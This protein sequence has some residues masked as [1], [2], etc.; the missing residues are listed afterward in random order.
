MLNEVGC[1]LSCH[2]SVASGKFAPRIN[3]QLVNWFSSNGE[4]DSLVLDMSSNSTYLRFVC[5][6]AANQFAFGKLNFASRAR[7][8]IQLVSQLKCENDSLCQL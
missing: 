2:E 3:T 8:K 4:N 6:H 5:C 7:F 1:V